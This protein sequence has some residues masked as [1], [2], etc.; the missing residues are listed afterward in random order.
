VSTSPEADRLY[1]TLGIQTVGIDTFRAAA[2]ISLDRPYRLFPS[3]ESI[4]EQLLLRRHEMS[5]ALVE[6]AIDVGD[7]RQRLLA[8]SDM[9]AR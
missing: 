5:N 9:L 7:P 3:N 1:Y 6:D 4:V 2:G 8:I